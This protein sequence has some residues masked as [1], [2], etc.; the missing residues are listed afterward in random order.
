MPQAATR[1]MEERLLRSLAGLEA[2]LV[3]A[4]EAAAVGDDAD[5]EKA[6]ASPPHS[7]G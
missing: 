5:A 2:R 3:Q 6:V 1:K 4:N 7:K